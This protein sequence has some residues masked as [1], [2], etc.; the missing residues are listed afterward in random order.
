[1]DGVK[2]KAKAL[3]KGLITAEQAARMSELLLLIFWT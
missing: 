3:R 2:V 1:M